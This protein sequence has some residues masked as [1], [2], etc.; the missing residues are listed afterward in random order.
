MGFL[1]RCATA[2]D[3][4][5]VEAAL[6]AM[7][8]LSSYGIHRDCYVVAVAEAPSTE[9]EPLLQQVKEIPGV[10]SCLVTSVNLEDEQDGGGMP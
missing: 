6:T 5:Q 7:P 1:A 3:C 2:R 8:G 4:P 9:L 10:L